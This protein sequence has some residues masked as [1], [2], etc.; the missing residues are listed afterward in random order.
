M[1]ENYLVKVIP[2]INPETYVFCHLIEISTTK[3]IVNWGINN[4]FEY[5]MYDSVKD[6]IN[7]ADCII[8]TSFHLSHI[9]AIGLFPDKPVYCSIPTAILGR[10]QLEEF[11]ETIKLKNKQILFYLKPIQIQ[12]SQPFKVKNVEICA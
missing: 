6:I 3:I 4:S 7:S 11:A 2:L 12:F 5:E 9:G 8:V 1:L 10:I